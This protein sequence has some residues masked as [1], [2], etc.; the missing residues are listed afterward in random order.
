MRQPV[1]RAAAALVGS[2]HPQP[3]VAVTALTTAIA[4]AA[5]RGGASALVGLAVLSGQLSIGW[6]NDVL[7]VR[8]DR[9]AGRSDKPV[10]SGVVSD[11]AVGLAALA[12]A[13]ICVPLSL[14]S[15]LLAGP[16]HLVGVACGW[17]Y[18]LGLKR[19]L[20]SPLP[21]AVAFGL[22]PAFVTLGLEGQPWPH[23]WVLTAGA[24]LGTGA[25]FLNVVPDIEADRAAGIQGLPQRVGARAARAVG[26]VLLAG[27]AV[28][29]TLGPGDP[30]ALGWL[31]LAAAVALGTAAALAPRGR[32]P[33]ALALGVAALDVV[34]LVA[35]GSALA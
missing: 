8:R 32:L 19:T 34:L 33:F 9:A 21:F 16:A 2:C 26:A 20:V 7:D 5:G 24:L 1:G 11:R 15:G 28:A 25:H 35:H 14:A 18:N 10:A 6:S 22:L 12:A 17:A 30:G 23:W 31:G 3:T 4:V 27:A 13:A 29:V